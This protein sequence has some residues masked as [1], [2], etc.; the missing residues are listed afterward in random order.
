MA[1]QHDP[2]QGR[3]VVVHH[4]EEHDGKE[5][6]DHH[7]EAGTGNEI[8]D[9]LQ[10]PHPGHRIADPAG[11]EISQ[12]QTQQMIEQLGPQGHVDA[13]GGVGEQIGAQPRQHHLEHRHRQQTDSQH[14]Q[15]GQPAMHQHLVDHHLK[16][17][18]RD[19]GEQLDEEG[20]DQHFAEQSCG[21]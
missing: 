5:E 4:R 18:R 8:A 17:Q 2:G 3:A 6:I 20:G 19:Q 15:G 7:R 14:I 12:R 10:L 13:V 21:I 9:R 1:P 16:E 11:L